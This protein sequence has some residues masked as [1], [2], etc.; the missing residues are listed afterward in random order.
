MKHRE[1]HPSNV[2]EGENKQ[3]IR[4][5]FSPEEKIKIVMEGLKGDSSIAALCRKYNIHR[6]LLSK[7]SQDFIEAGEKGLGKK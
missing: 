2:I 4:R 1:N 3:R 7:W 6:N 5:Y